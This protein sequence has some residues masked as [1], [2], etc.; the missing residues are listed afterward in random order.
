MATATAEPTQ[1]H[2]KIVV[3]FIHSIRSVFKTMVGIDVTIGKPHLKSNPAPSYDI[4]G[5]IGFSGGVVGSIV[6]SFEMSAASKL[7]AAFVGVPIPT[8]SSDFADAIGE[9]TN[10]IAGG[11]KS[12][13]G[14]GLSISVPVVIV[15]KGHALSQLSD[16]VCVQIPCSSPVGDFAIEINM[17]K[18]MA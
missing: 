18:G 1:G 11:A 14:E 15:G 7:V 8:D 17:K 16:V 2:G 13:L 9:L 6:V 5:V 3:P 12:G 10:I 4:S